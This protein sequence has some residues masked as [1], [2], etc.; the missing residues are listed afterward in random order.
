MNRIIFALGFIIVLISCKKMETPLTPPPVIVPEESI[1]FT[2]NL[3]TGTVN[4]K[5]TMA[6]VVSVNSK[7]PAAGL[8]YS[9][10]A[11]WTDSSK[12]IFKLDTSLSSSTLSQNIPGFK[13]TGNYTLSISVTSKS[14]TTNSL[15]K[16]ISLSRN[17]IILYT[18]TIP[19]QV[20]GVSNS[21][22]MT[23]NIL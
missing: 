4:V 22:L 11:T 2:T 19:L 16:S 18:T 14:T 1:K 3:D 7:I 13:K 10:T 8:L 21:N 5:D 17:N 9:I 20:S 23:G 12:Q 15:S 6:L